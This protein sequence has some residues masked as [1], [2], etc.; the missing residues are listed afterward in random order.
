MGKSQMQRISSLS[1][2][3]TGGQEHYSHVQM[4]P[5]DPILGTVIAWRNDKDPN[6]MN[7]GVGAYRTDEGT[8]Y[9][10]PSVKAAEAQIINDKKYNKEYLGVDGYIPFVQ[11]SQRLIF[12][13]NCKAVKEGRIASLQ[14]L[15]GTGSLT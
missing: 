15:S 3:L 4:A 14:T 8:P 6:K 7:L 10:F 9:I 13:D 12:G 1:N 11:S 5:A 2:Q